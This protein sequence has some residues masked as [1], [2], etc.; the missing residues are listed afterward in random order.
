[1]RAALL[2]V[3]Q[4]FGPGFAPSLALQL[5]RAG[6]RFFGRA[7][8]GAGVG[9]H[10]QGRPWLGLRAPRAAARAHSGRG[11]SEPLLELRPTL[12]AGIYHLDARGEV[13]PPLVARSAQVTSFAGGVGLEAAVRLSQVLL[14][15]VELSAL[16]LTPR[17]AI[18]VLSDQYLF[19]WPFMTASIGLGVDF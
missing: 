17:P 18:A 1:V 15:G 10:L 5:P 12:A 8:R 19:A 7:G 2:G 11:I 3:T 4:R 6:S 14:L 13:E 9:R 16:E